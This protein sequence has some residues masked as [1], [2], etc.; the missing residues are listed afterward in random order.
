MPSLPARF[1]LGNAALAWALLALMAV[2]LVYGIVHERLFLSTRWL[3]EG[4]TAFLMYAAGFAVC[5]ALWLL[6]APGWLPHA[7]LLIAVMWAAWWWG[8]LAPLAVLYFLAS[9]NALGRCV[10]ATRNGTLATLLGAAVWMLLLWIALHFYWNRWWIY[11]MV[12]AIPFVFRRPS[13]RIEAQAKGPR[14][15]LALALLLF[16]LGAHF[17]VS[18]K[19]EISDDGLSMHLALPMSVEM[20][21]RWAFNHLQDTWALMPAGADSLYTGVL[22][23]GGEGAAKLLNFAFLAIACLLVVQ[24][25]ERWTTRTNALLLAALFASTPVVQLVTG[26]LFVENVWGALLVGAVVAVLEGELVLAAALMGAAGATKLIAV[27]Y[28][29]PV[30]GIVAWLAYEGRRWRD[31]A[32]AAGAF[33]LLAAPPYAFAYAKSGNPIFPFANNVFKSPD[34]DSTKAF[35]DPRYADVHPS[36]DV[37]YRMTFKSDEYIEGEGGAAGFQYFLLL[38]PAVLLIKKSD[39][40]IVMLV[41]VGGSALVLLGAPN[42]R[43]LYGALPLLTVAIA[44]TPWTALAPMLVA[45]NLWFLPSSGFYHGDF[46][47]FDKG[48]KQKY[49]EEQ[50]PMRVLVENANRWFP[51]EPVAFFS[52][53]MIAGLRAPAFTDTWHS[54]RYWESIRFSVHASAIAEELK[55]RHIRYVIA[56]ANRFSRFEVFHDFQLRWLDAVP[57]GKAGNLALFELR[58]TEV[59]PVHDTGA[60]PLGLHDDMDARMEYSG[61]WLHDP[62]FKPPVKGTVSYSDHAGDFLR[63]WFEGR[64]V[65]LLYTAAANRG[66]G[67]VFLDGQRVRV[68]NEY[69]EATKWQSEVRMDDFVPGVH[70][71]E[72]RVTGQK[73][74]RSAGAFVDFDALRIE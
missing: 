67:E 16:V 51:N 62:Q 6:R 64:A 56:P 70:K 50:A 53:S 47:F 25:A 63:V 2:L 48:K 58:N 40:A 3:P 22:L 74:E 37:L 4:V 49:I 1:R 33:V 68:V 69:S 14:E 26:S 55:K 43:Y 42:F 59:P 35:A 18:L 7:T 44:W 71:F 39:Q 32:I 17:L 52:T 28:A 11:A 23:L 66:I 46:A 54:D 61:A 10:S 34:Y 72:L 9:S 8:P 57:N 31:L 13:W 36:W 24:L 45:L 27:A 30:L 5:G 19:P 38:L 21:G 65:T 15:G 60:L 20:H 12:F 29:V 41:A 73:D